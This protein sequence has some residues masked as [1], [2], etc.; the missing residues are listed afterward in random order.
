MDR[1]DNQELRLKVDLIKEFLEKVLPDLGP[2]S[3]IMREYTDY[4]SSARAEEIRKFAEEN[5]LN[6]EF[7]QKEVSEYEYSGIIRNDMILDQLKDKKFLE[8]R[9]L[10]QRMI[11]FI[12]KHVEK[13][14]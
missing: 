1:S 10:K 2:D 14:E 4:E 7:I 8:K 5:N 12:K 13:F 11:D 9:R 3:S 6:A